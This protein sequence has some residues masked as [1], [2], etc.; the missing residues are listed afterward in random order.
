MTDKYEFPDEKEGMAVGIDP[1]DD[2]DFEVEVVDDTPAQDK[3]RKPLD[4]EVADPDEAELESYS[5]K[6]QGRIKELTHARH[7]ERRAKEAIEREKAEL[8]RAAKQLLDENRQMRAVIDNGSRQ[9][10]EQALTIADTAV[11]KAKRALREAQE[12][13]DTDAI[14]EAQEAL[15]DAKIRASEAKK[16]RPTSLQ[17]QEEVVQTQQQVLA[18][19]KPD[20]KTL[21]WQARNQWF[22][23]P[24]Y[25]EITSFAMGLHNK[26]VRSGV[27][28]TSDDYFEQ[29]DARLKTTFPD[30]FGG[31]VGRQQPQGTSKRPTSVVAPATRSSGVK[32]VQ[33]T[34]TQVALASKL[35]LTPQQYAAQVAK[36]E[37]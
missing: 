12:S 13:F 34:A 37:N 10:V 18:E 9:Y 2:A 33:L 31:S 7:D 35:G 19:P 11:E 26:L 3:G 8:E 32:K 23:D 24:E 16:I 15:F 1:V 36:L 17:E 4:R 6:V 29:I 21:R 14:I 30:M 28:P 25:T 20:P 27:D 5:D 22:G